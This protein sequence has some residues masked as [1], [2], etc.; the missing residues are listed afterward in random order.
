MNIIRIHL[1]EQIKINEA[2]A[3]K[4]ERREKDRAFRWW[5]RMGK[6]PGLRK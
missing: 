1:P 3:T 6:R 4:E 5:V 2:T